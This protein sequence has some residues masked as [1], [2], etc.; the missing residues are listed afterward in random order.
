MTEEEMR[1]WI[2]EASYTQLLERWRFA[3][4][5]SPWFQGE[6]GDYYTAAM[7][8][9]RREVGDDAHVAASKLIGFGW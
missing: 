1:R 4:V 8:R 3:P 5:G 7:A 6:I 9:R 2:D